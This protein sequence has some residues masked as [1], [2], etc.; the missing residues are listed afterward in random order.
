MS[1]TIRFGCFEADLAAHQ[2][3]KGG[4]RIRLRDQSFQVLAALVEHPGQVVTREDLRH[5]LWTG[6]VFVDFENSLNTAVARLREAL[7]ESADRPRYIETLPRIGYR[8]IAPVVESHDVSP[9][10]VSPRPDGGLVVLPFLNLSGDPAQEYFSDAI[11]EEIITELAGLAPDT[12]RVIARTTAMRY[13][14]THKDVARIG[15]ELGVDYVV[16]G[17]VRRTGDGVAL[18]VQLVRTSDQKHVFA[19][20]YQAELSDL[21]G[22]QSLAAREIAGHVDIGPVAEAIRVQLAAGARDTRKPTLNLAAYDEYLRGRH[23][24]AT[25][26]PAAL[27]TGR[28]HFEAAIARDPNLALAYDSLAEI[29]W[30]LGYFG[31]M[32]PIDAFSTGVLYAMRALEIDNTLGETHALL[33]QYHKQIDFN[34]PEVDREMARALELSPASPIVRERYAFNALM[35]RARLEEAVTELERA[36]EWD[37]LS[38]PPRTMLAAVLLLWRRFD[39]AMEQARLLLDLEP[40]A[41]WAYLVIGACH[42]DRGMFEEAIAAH[43]RANE[44]SGDSALTVGWLGLSLGLGGHAAEAR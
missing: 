20:R 15:R 5:R 42:R 33:G 35:P 31:F 43:R 29:Y 38:A 41:Y 26:T 37:P 10:P 8:F 44:L 30:Y 11:T 2:L 6:D 4:A 13:K 39:R 27:A 12:L 23:A 36:L 18:N 19:R 40:N 34:W 24:L 28:Q 7:S 17:G 21:F 1:R 32:R 9:Q 3:Y 22:M 25:V 14:R 16:E